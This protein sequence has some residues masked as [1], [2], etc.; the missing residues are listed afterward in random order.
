MR[1]TRG[2]GGAAGAGQWLYDGSSRR[3]S[4]AGREPSGPEAALEGNSDPLPRWLP[5]GPSGSR[6]LNSNQNSG[7]SSH[8]L[9]SMSLS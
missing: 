1:G 3:N 8:V 7:F 4:L 2:G 6:A 5:F 9:C